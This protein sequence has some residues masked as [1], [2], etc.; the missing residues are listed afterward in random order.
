MK[1]RFGRGTV[2]YASLFLKKREGTV[3]YVFLFL[4]KREPPLML[5]YGEFGTVA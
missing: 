5:L 3:S 1:R 4:K 2:S